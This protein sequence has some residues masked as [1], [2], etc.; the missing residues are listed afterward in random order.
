MAGRVDASPGSGLSLDQLIGIPGNDRFSFFNFQ[1]KDGCFFPGQGCGRPQGPFRV[2]QVA[3]FK[4][5][6]VIRGG[7]VRNHVLVLCQHRHRFTGKIPG[8][9]DG[10]Q[11]LDSLLTGDVE[12]DAHL[13]PADS[14][15]DF[16]RYHGFHHR[17]IP[18]DGIRVYKIQGGSR[19]V[20]LHRQHIVDNAEEFLP[21][22]QPL[23]PVSPVRISLD[24]SQAHGLPDHGLRAMAG[25]I[26]H[27]CC[28]YGPRKSANHQCRR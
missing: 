23:R 20:R 16:S 22:D 11:N 26:R 19:G 6:L 9:N 2:I 4:H 28:R 24:D 25:N 8:G 1:K 3:F 15:G 5:D 12:P 14:F 10:G 27:F 21:L 17:N 7:P 13:A 18:F